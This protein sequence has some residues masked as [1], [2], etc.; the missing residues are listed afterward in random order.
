[1]SDQEK[2]IK[3]AEAMGWTDIEEKICGTPP[4]S[5]RVLFG[6]PPKFPGGGKDC[7]PKYFTDAND[8][9]AV[10]EWMRQFEGTQKYRDFIFELRLLQNKCVDFNPML[11]ENYQIG[12]FACAAYKV[13]SQ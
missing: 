3:L 9:Y 11:Y 7:V 4:Y 5:T 1:M 13:I 10:L 8:D 6:C 12:D 2:R